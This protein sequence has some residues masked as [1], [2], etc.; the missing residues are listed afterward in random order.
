[1]CDRSQPTGYFH[2]GSAR[3]ALFNWLFARHNDGKFIVRVEDTDRTRYNPE[4]VPICW[5]V[6]AGWAWIGTKAPK[7]ADRLVPTTSRIGWTSITLCPMADRPGHAYHCYCSPKRLAALR[8]GQ[9]EAKDDVG[10]DRHCRTLTAAERAEREAEALSLSCVSRCPLRARPPFTTCCMHHHRGQ[11][12]AGRPGAAQERRFSHLSPGVVVDD[13]LMDISQSCAATSGCPRCPN[14]CCST[15]LWL[16]DA[17][18]SPPAL[19]LAPS[20]QGKLSSATAG[21]G[22]RV[23][24]AGLPARGHDQLPGPRRLEPDDK[25][26]IFSREELIEH[27]DLPGINHSP[28]RF[29]Y[30]RL[31]WINGYY[32][33]QA[34]S[35]DLARRLVPFVQAAGWQVTAADLEPV[36]PLIQE[37]IK[38]LK[39]VVDKAAFFSRSISSTIQ[40]SWWA[41]K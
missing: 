10:Y 12:Q 4:A 17:G 37:R 22:A 39:E 35:P 41:K 3:T 25:T 7:W 24:G 36:V 20:G 21:G 11:R 14:T 38:T 18:F 5:P 30:E 34:S 40:V 6:C 1:V 16:G 2:V 15:G 19:I 13:H 32:I 9:R 23:S 33:R 27:F 8:E 28:A 31:E 26:E 29:S